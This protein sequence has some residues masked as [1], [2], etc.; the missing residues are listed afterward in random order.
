MENV[1]ITAPQV[2]ISMDRPVP[3]VKGHA[4]LVLL[5]ILVYLVLETS[6][7]IM[8]NALDLAQLELLQLDPA[9]LIAMNLVSDVPDL[10]LNASDVLM[11]TIDSKRNV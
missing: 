10:Q 9:V 7:L 3:L 6:L 5:L 8:A 2:S 4:R 1:L 11:G